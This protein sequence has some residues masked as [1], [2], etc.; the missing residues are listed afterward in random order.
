MSGIF[1]PASVKVVRGWQEGRE[2]PLERARS[3]LGRDEHADIPL[4]RDMRVE[5]KHA[6]VVREGPKYVLVN[7]GAPPDFTLVNEEPVF[8]R[9]ELQDGDRV[10]LGQVLLRFQMRAAQNRRPAYGAGSARAAAPAP[11][12]PSG[13]P[14]L[15]RPP[16]HRCRG[17]IE[18]S[19][20]RTAR[21]RSRC[22][23]SAASVPRPN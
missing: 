3:L 8:E 23:S 6:F 11:L 14:E 9:R 21:V 10:Q 19:R 1:Q 20:V 12:L 7:N 4:F 18:V 5:K 2:Y 22:R 13:S 17:R 15:K 16:R